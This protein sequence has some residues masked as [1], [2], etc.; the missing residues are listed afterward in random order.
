MCFQRKSIE[1]REGS[2]ARIHVWMVST[3]GHC[4]TYNMSLTFRCSLLLMLGQVRDFMSGL[5]LWSPSTSEATP[6]RN[7]LPAAIPPSSEHHTSSPTPPAPSEPSASGF[8]ALETSTISAYIVARPDLC[9]R[10]GPSS[11]ANEWTVKEVSCQGLGLKD[12]CNACLFERA[13]NTGKVYPRTL[14]LLTSTRGVESPIEERIY[15]PLCWLVVQYPTLL[16]ASAIWASI[17]GLIRCVV[18]QNRQG[19]IL[20]NTIRGAACKL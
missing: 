13:A 6:I 14:T 1:A 8:Y 3:W 4:Q 12:V 15:H 16:G 17:G 9:R 10:V 18:G 5:G 2:S 20:Q 7:G 11:T 19:H